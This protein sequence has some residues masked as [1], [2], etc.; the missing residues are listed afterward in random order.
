METILYHHL[1]R[2]CRKFVKKVNNVEQKLKEKG[3]ENSKAKTYAEI[4]KE[5]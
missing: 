4:T 3:K 1:L 5:M 2:Q